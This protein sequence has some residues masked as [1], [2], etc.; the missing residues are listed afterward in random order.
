VGCLL[1]SGNPC[2]AD[3]TSCCCC[4]CGRPLLVALLRHLCSAA[5]P[6]N[7]LQPLQRLLLGVPASSLTLRQAGEG[8]AAGAAAATQVAAAA[9][10]LVSNS[11]SLLA[12]GAGSQ[13]CLLW[14]RGLRDS[15][16][17]HTTNTSPTPC[18][19]C[20]LCRLH[21]HCICQLSQPP[22]H[23]DSTAVLLACTIH[24]LACV[25]SQAEP[26]GASCPHDVVCSPAM[27]GKT[28]LRVVQHM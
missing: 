22:K 28:S 12:G 8:A 17:V 20:A 14:L 18:I 5:P 13:A 7:A 25:E 24:T 11:S 15:R 21:S 16:W 1:S 4:C 10:A 27:P 26:I 19:T 6:R 2:C 9:E 23:I 3:Y